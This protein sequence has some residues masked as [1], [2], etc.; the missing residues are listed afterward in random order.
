[1]DQIKAGVVAI[2]ALL[3]LVGSNLHALNL[4][5]TYSGS[6]APCKQL[7]ETFFSCMDG[8]SV[9]ISFSIYDNYN[10]YYGNFTAVWQNGVN[11]TTPINIYGGACTVPSYSTVVCFTSIGSIP[12]TSGNGT[13]NRTL[14]ILFR[15]D[16]FPEVEFVKNLTVTI[17]HNMTSQESESVGMYNKMLS[18]YSDMNESYNY[19][20]DNYN[21]CDLQLR[22]NLT[23]FGNVLSNVSIELDNFSLSQA[24]SNETTAQQIESGTDALFSNFSGS[25]NRILNNIYASRANTAA[26]ENLYNY[27]LTILSNCS[28]SNFTAYSSTINGSIAYLSNYPI[29]NTLSGSAKYLNLTESVLSKEKSLIASCLATTEARKKES[30][31]NASSASTAIKYAQYGGPIAA[32][33]VALYA[34]IKI[35]NE[36]ETR[37]IRER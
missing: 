27:N 34:A 8:K 1:M 29:Y 31:A 20:C 35:K 37:K 24:Y 17:R 16:N 4:F 25:S 23:A 14:S 12:M 26:A 10:P 2:A 9:T 6:S 30:A 15:S 3:I 36:R 21:I 18:N 11:F 28:Y 7:N 32:I 19:F 13:V 22:S 33:I 5:S